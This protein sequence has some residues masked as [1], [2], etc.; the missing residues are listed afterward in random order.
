MHAGAQKALIASDQ[1]FAGPLAAGVAVRE[2]LDE[3]YKLGIAEGRP[4]LLC[5]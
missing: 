5:S 3:R 4:F 1:G 2:R